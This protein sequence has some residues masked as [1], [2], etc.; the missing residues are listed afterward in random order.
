VVFTRTVVLDGVL[1][2]VLGKDCRDLVSAREDLDGL[3]VLNV[4]N[5]II[6]VLFGDLLAAPDL[7]KTLLLLLL[8]LGRFLSADPAVAGDKG[9]EAEE[10]DRSLVGGLDHGLQRLVLGKSRLLLGVLELLPGLEELVG[11]VG[12]ASCEVLVL[13]PVD[14][15]RLRHEALPVL[16]LPEPELLLNSLVLEPLVLLEA[17]LQGEAAGRALGVVELESRDLECVEALGEDLGVGGLDE[18]VDLRRGLLKNKAPEVRNSCDEL[19]A[20][21]VER[22][23]E[24][25]S[26]ADCVCVS[27]ALCSAARV[28]TY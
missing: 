12:Q 3:E 9:E 16:G 5:L 20:L 18:V 24:D 19:G 11:R 26:L 28:D 1:P 15:D 17:E 6:L 27:N 10:A 22:G 14:L 25:L 23:L 13:L 7:V 4:L 21:L 2:E 8:G